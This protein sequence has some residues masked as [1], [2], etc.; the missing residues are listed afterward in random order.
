MKKVLLLLFFASIPIL[1]LCEH[2]LS[3]QMTRQIADME[4]EKKLLTEQLEQN[5]IDAAKA[6]C[7][8]AI[9]AKAVALGLT[10][11]KPDSLLPV[12]SSLR[13]GKSL[14]LFGEDPTREAG[15]RGAS[16]HSL[17]NH[18]G[19]SRLKCTR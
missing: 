12:E 11:P 1:Y 13:Q 3:F 5:K 14:P 4:E 18:N 10:F 7:Y 9:E 19:D 16:S 8:P 17:A 2:N 15:L 6:F